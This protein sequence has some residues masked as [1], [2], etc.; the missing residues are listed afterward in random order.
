[1][2]FSTKKWAEEFERQAEHDGASPGLLRLSIASINLQLGLLDGMSADEARLLR[3][4]HELMAAA[5]TDYLDSLE[6]PAPAE[7]EEGAAGDEIQEE[8]EAGPGSDIEAAAEGEKT[9]PAT[10]AGTGGVLG[11]NSPRFNPDQGTKK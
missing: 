4:T 7:A 9:P 3:L 8:A 10:P 1:M 5:A 11:A 2:S 6:P